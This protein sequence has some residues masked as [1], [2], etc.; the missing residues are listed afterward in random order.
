MASESM[1]LIGLAVL[2]VE[3]EEVGQELAK[4]WKWICLVG[5]IDVIGGIFALLCP[6]VATEVAYVIVVA[7]LL[8][9]GVLHALGLCFAERGHRTSSFLVGVCQV[10]LALVLRLYALQGLTIITICIAV[11]FIIEGMHRIGLAMQNRDMHGFV[12]TLVN[13]CAAVAFSV[14]ILIALP[15]SAMYTIGILVGVNL[16]SVGSCRVAISFQ[17]RKLALGEGDGGGGPSSSP[18][19]GGQGGDGGGAAA[20]G[21]NAL[22]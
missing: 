4:N 13:G 11:L 16:I 21:G 12:P 17:G 19:L 7:A 15:F 20:S 22:V 9:A 5:V 18:L 8:V 10:L 3:R 1:P 6:I 2:T 14:L